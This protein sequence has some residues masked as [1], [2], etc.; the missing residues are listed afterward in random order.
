MRFF[1]YTFMRK[2]RKTFL[3]FHLD[4][5]SLTNDLRGDHHILY[6]FKFFACTTNMYPLMRLR[7]FADKNYYKQTFITLIKTKLYI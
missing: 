4:F 2:L 3:F 7:L 5:V 1:S 6:F